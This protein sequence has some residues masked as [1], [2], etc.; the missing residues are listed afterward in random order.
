M[1]KK[2]KKLSKSPRELLEG[3][4]GKEVV[5]EIEH[6]DTPVVSGI[7]KAYDGKF[8]LIE[9]YTQ[10]HLYLSDLMEGESLERN[11]HYSLPSKLINASLIASLQTLEDI[12][13]TIKKEN[14]KDDN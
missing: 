7:L 11:I 13:Y 4:V 6:Q 12:L 1:K 10:H 2:Q 5:M 9:N 3:Y 8:A 14:K